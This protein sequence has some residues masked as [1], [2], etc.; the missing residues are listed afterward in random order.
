[1]IRGL[2]LE[3]ERS[4]ANGGLDAN[5]L[6]VNGIPSVTMG[7]GQQDPH[8][9]KEMLNLDEFDNACRIGLRLA[10]QV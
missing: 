8:T 6:T 5:W 1:M 3:P 9:V 4:I 10:T 2:G 7:C